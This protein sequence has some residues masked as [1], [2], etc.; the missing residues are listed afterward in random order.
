MDFDE[1]DHFDALHHVFLH[2]LEHHLVGQEPWGLRDHLPNM[3]NPLG[4]AAQDG[5]AARPRHQRDEL[6]EVEMAGQENAG[7][8]AG[9]RRSLPQPDIIDLTGEDDV[10]APVRRGLFGQPLAPV[11]PARSVP[12]RQSENQ[13]RR[14]SQHQNAPPRLNR[15]DG[16]YVNDQQVIVLSSSDDDLPLG[17]SPRRNINHNV[18]NMNHNPHLHRPNNRDNAGRSTRNARFGNQPRRPGPASAQNLNNHHQNNNDE[19]NNNDVLRPF[20]QLVQNIPFFQFLS[21]HHPPFMPQPYMAGRNQNLDDD[22]VITGARN[23]NNDANFGHIPVPGGH[24]VLGLGPI[25]LDYAAHPFPPMQVP[26]VPGEGRGPPKPPHIPPK[27][28]RPG[29]TRDT[30]ED[31]VAICPSCDQELAYDPE[32]DDDAS[33]TPTRK[34]RSKK[35]TAEHH[36]WAVKACGHVYCKRCFDNRRPTVRGTTH[37]SFRP[38]REGSKKLF[39]AVEDCDSDVSAKSAWVGIFM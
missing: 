31:V 33:A 28:A 20:S 15:S 10:E 4:G 17:A 38:D 9:P 18:N 37:V 30:G 7:A 24:G 39:C 25:H 8:R 22:I 6:V 23:V 21:N 29:F 32:G 19:G 5:V 11:Q 14:R 12:Q 26:A 16:S 13:R 1:E 2:H 3:D 36:F 34:P 27:P 35:A